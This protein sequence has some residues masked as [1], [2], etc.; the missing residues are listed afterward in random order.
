METIGFN[1]VYNKNQ[2]KIGAKCVVRDYHKP[3]IKVI[4]DII[5][6]HISSR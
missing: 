2:D 6:I 1:T 3:H 4:C 5:Y